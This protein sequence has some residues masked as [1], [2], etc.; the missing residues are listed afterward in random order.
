MG[1]AA[2][3]FEFPKASPK[4]SLAIDSWWLKPSKLKN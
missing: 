2:D 4:Y 1:D 3:I